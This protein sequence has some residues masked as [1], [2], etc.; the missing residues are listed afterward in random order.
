MRGTYPESRNVFG[1]PDIAV[2]MEALY[3]LPSGDRV[4]IIDTATVGQSLARI[5]QL[6]REG[7]TE[8][9]RPRTAGCARVNH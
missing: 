6:Y 9:P 4:R 2:I 1:A 5:L 3:D 7:P 8:P